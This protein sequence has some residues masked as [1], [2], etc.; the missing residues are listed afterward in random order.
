MFTF[1]KRGSRFVVEI[2]LCRGTRPGGISVI[3]SISKLDDMVQCNMVNIWF[4]PFREQ[5]GAQ[6]N[7]GCIEHV[8]A[9][10]LLTSVARSKKHKLFVTLV[11]LMIRSLVMNCLFF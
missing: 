8:G 9:L 4:H 11:K 7:R 6:S 5:A 2:F 3:K 1:V 10:L